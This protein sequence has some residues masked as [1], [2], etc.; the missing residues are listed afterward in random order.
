MLVTT[1]LSPV[2]MKNNRRSTYYMRWV[3]CAIRTPIQKCQLGAYVPRWSANP[4][5]ATAVT[6]VMFSCNSHRWRKN[7]SA[8]YQIR[9]SGKRPI[10][11]VS[12]MWAM[13]LNWSSHTCDG[14]S[15][16]INKFLW[17]TSFS[18]LL[19]CI[20]SR[21]IVVTFASQFVLVPSSKDITSALSEPVTGNEGG[22]L[23]SNNE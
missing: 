15:N 19:H 13:R 17:T 4:L 18:A 1:Y 2:S 14:R 6:G 8:L 23:S 7:K 5:L 20:D 10:I 21:I 3:H 22:I 12:L 9:I 11:F 16:I